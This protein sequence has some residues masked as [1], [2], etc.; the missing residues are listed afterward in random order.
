MLLPTGAKILNTALLGINVFQKSVILD[1]RLTFAKQRETVAKK[2]SRSAA[3]LAR[4]MLN[5]RGPYQLPVE[6]ETVELNCQEPTVV[7]RAADEQ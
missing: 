1:Q 5:V 7:T 2:A 6:A 3:S 4:L